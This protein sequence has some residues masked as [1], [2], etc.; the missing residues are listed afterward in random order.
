MMIRS[1][2]KHLVSFHVAGHLA[3]CLTISAQL[4]SDLHLSCQIVARLYGGMNYL[5]KIH[6]CYPHSSGPSAKRTKR[7]SQLSRTNF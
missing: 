7:R 1:H 2:A 4:P 5:P 3:A 6:L